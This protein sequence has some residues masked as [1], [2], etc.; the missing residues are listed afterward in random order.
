MKKSLIIVSSIIL[1]ITI[2]VAC[3]ELQQIGYAVGSQANSKS[4]PLTEA[5]VIAGLKQALKVGT[6]TAVK[7]LAVTNGYYGDALVKISMPPEA[8][9]ILAN[10]NKLP[11]GQKLVSDLELRINRSAEDAAKEAAPIFANAITSMSVADAW[12][13]LRGAD[14]AATAYLR[15]STYQS[16]LTLYKP[17]IKSSID[18]PLVAG[19]STTQSWN[20][21]TSKW[22]V[23]ANSPVGALSNLKPVNTQLDDYLTRKALDGLF[24]KVAQEE[25]SIRKDPMARV[26]DLLKRVFGAK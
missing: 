15:K 19:I 3:A 24:L 11:G 7:N 25:K 12:G 20:T 8:Q 13:I 10:L 22:N 1:S 14:T 16:L 21:L 23:V 18:K 4:V 5:D 6:D 26:T 17:K 9:T 2:F